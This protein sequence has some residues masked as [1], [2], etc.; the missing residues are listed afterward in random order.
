MCLEHFTNAFSTYNIE[1]NTFKEKKCFSLHH[2]KYRASKAQLDFFYIKEE[3]QMPSN[4]KIL[5]N[6]LI[7][8]PTK[9]AA[10]PVCF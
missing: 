9:D 1:P 8:V 10:V 4:Y 6:N 7:E 2:R 3:W 5:I